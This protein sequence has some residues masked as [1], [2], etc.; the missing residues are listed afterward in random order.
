[1]VSKLWTGTE[2]VKLSFKNIRGLYSSLF[3]YNQGFKE[4]LF[5]GLF[6]KKLPFLGLFCKN[7]DLT[8]LVWLQILK[9][10]IICNNHSF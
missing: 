2:K 6:Y 9:A 4:L 1:M 3:P 5:L 8:S 10:I 7:L